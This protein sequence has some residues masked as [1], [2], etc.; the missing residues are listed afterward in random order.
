MIEY[1]FPEHLS[2]APSG[3]KAIRL[4]LTL[5]KCSGKESGFPKTFQGKVWFNQR[6]ISKKEAPMFG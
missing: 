6:S 5:D 3:R 1:S 2:R 4:R